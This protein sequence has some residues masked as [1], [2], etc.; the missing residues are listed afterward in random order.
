MTWAKGTVAPNENKAAADALPL[1][2]AA[3]RGGGGRWGRQRRFKNFGWGS[4]DAGPGA[5][6][7]GLDLPGFWSAWSGPEAGSGALHW[8]RGSSEGESDGSDGVGMALGRV[9]EWRLSVRSVN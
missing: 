1:A 5:A 9:R 6:E 7:A 4:T 2:A 3:R 8:A